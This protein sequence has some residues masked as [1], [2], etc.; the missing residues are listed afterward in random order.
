MAI[1]AVN[2]RSQLDGL[3]DIPELN[4]FEKSIGKAA[5]IRFALRRAL[6]RR[7]GVVFTFGG[8]VHGVL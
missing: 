4:G 7:V 3:V 1:Q 8:C 5:L 2:L 6:E